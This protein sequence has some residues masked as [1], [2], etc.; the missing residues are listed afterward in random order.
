MVDASAVGM[1]VDCPE[2]AKKM[3]IPEVES[4][5]PE[6]TV[7]PTANTDTMDAPGVDTDTAALEPK[8]HDTGKAHAIKPEDFRRLLEETAR[9]M[10][11]QLEKAASE[12]RGALE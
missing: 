3:T 5:E 12:V 9:A 11:P 7:D 6:G 10:V 2:C 1:E 4:S 8:P